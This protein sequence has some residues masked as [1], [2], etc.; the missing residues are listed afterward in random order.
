MKTKILG[1]L[2]AC[3]LLTIQQAKADTLTVFNV[4]GTAVTD[5]S[6]HLDLP[7]TGTLTID[8]ELGII[9]NAALSIQSLGTWSRLYPQI[10]PYRIDIAAD[11][12]NAGTSSDGTLFGCVGHSAGGCHDILAI[13]LSDTPLALVAAGGGSIVSGFA[14]LYD[15]NFNNIIS[16]TG[17]LTQV[18]QVPLPGALPLFATGLGALGLLGWRR[19]RK[20]AAVA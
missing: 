18:N 16:V 13:F 14:S 19:K 1:A 6:G 7:L 9:S 15:S 17:T 20:A 11:R 8:E 4:Q 12:Y 3:L 5:I 10:D 2:V